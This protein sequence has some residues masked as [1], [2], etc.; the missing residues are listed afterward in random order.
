MN[1]TERQMNEGVDFDD[2]DDEGPA[3]TICGCEMDA[4]ECYKCHG[5]GGRDLYEENPI[6]YAPGDWEHCDECKGIGYYWQCP[7]VPHEE[8]KND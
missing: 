6:E 2:T 8:S 3:C 5:D 1:R 7:N 4:E